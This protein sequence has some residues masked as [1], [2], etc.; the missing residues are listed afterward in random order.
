MS[1]VIPHYGDPKHALS[2]VNQLLGQRGLDAM[3]IIVVD[4]ASPIAFPE[5][6]DQRVT[7]VRRTSNGGFGSAVN[8][9]AAYATHP[10]LLIMNSDVLVEPA[11]VRNLLDA[12]P[13]RA[14]SGPAVRTAGRIEATGRLFP[15][16]GR[17][18]LARVHVLQRF[19][20]RPRYLKAIGVDLSAV[21]GQSSHVDWLA[22]VVMLLPT[23]VFREVGGFD[24]SFFMY[25]EE[26]DLQRRLA[27]LGV[28]RV[29]VGSVEVEHA[30][31]ASSAPDRTQSWLTSSQLRYAEKWGGHRRTRAAMRGVALVNF[32]TGALRRVAGRP[33]RPLA[34]LR[35]ELRDISG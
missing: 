5:A 18:A 30:G 24:T 9:G 17:I 20:S 6:V 15:S 8:H 27:D 22:G 12:T 35:R 33:T 26:T 11:T 14:L 25:C 19:H 7:V 10:W 29:L 16:A 4:D 32:A 23:E 21:P 1:I 28:P 3:E 31:G 34:D 13:V 2:L